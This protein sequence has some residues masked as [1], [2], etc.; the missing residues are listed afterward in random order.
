MA[1]YLSRK[2][3]GVT[4][5]SIT[6]SN[7]SPAALTANTA[8]TPT[9]NGYA[10]QSYDSVT[11]SNS[12]PV[13]LTSGDIVKLG[14]NGYAIESY[15]NITPSDSPQ[16][17]SSGSIIKL[18]GSGRI[19]EDITVISPSD[20]TPVSMQQYGTYT[21]DH[22]SYAIRSYDTITPSNDTPVTLSGG[23]IYKMSGGGKAVA[24]VANKTPSDSAAP[25]ISSGAII[26]AASAGYL[27]ASSGLGKCKSGTFTMPSSGNTVTVTCGFKPKYIAYFKSG[28]HGIIYDED[29]STTNTFRST[30][31]GITEGTIGSQNYGLNAITSTGFSVRGGTTTGTFYYFAIG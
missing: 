10:I 12:S 28:T 29:W 6:P 7:S 25:Y 14:G 15:G 22:S 23:S 31:S 2:K 5:T 9:A 4:P 27:Y 16:T 11:P 8:V 13:T 1:I 17:L 18:N 3:G 24:S 21:V 20:S 26:K 30:S 19:V